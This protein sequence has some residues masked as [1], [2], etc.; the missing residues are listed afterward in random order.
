MIAPPCHAQTG[1]GVCVA[2]AANEVQPNVAA[3]AAPAAATGSAGSGVTGP[4]LILSSALSVVV[5]CMAAVAIIMGIRY[6]RNR[7]AR[8]LADRKFSNM[9]GRLS[10]ATNMGF[11]SGSVSNVSRQDDN[12]SLSNVDI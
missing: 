11:D 12:D 5:A 6:V 7:R 1:D 10:H 8:Q 4:T 2:V 9:Q 3:A